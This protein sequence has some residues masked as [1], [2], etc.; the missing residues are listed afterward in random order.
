MVGPQRCSFAE[1]PLLKLGEWHCAASGVAG[2]ILLVFHGNCVRRALQ[3]GQPV[4]TVQERAWTA[5][6][7][8]LR[9]S[10]AKTHAEWSISEPGKDVHLGT[11]AH[12]C[13]LA[14]RADAPDA[15]RGAAR[16]VPLGAGAVSAFFRVLHAELEDVGDG[17]PLRASP[18][19]L[20]V[21]VSLD[22]SRGAAAAAAG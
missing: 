9:R 2:D 4:Y 22:S 5:L 14:M 19:F 10:V 3:Q 1:L 21:Q 20:F 8:I 15:M 7:K 13:L 11:A 12:R 18:P 6:L 17:S 16:W